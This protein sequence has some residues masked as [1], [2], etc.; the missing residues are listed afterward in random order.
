V[1][2]QISGDGDGG[3]LTVHIQAATAEARDLLQQQLPAL[4]AGL[5]L[6][7]LRVEQLRVEQQQPG[8]SA[9]GWADGGREP[10]GGREQGDDEAPAW[11]PVAALRTAAR[12]GSVLRAP[13]APSGTLDVRA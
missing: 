8:A 12:P 4:R 3:G 11:S 6:R 5:E 10:R 9:Q 7:E 13:S 1:S 2:V